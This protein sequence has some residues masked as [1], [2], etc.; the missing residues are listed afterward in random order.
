MV[1]LE[2]RDADGQH[3][4]GSAFHIDDG[5][6]VT[7]RHVVDN[8]EIVRAA[9]HVGATQLSLESISVLLPSDPDVDLTILK[10]DSPSELTTRH[11]GGVVTCGLSIT[12]MW[13]STSTTG[14]TTASC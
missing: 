13:G 11:A 8:A 1:Y 5:Y 10:T 3:S 7:A 12:S 14:S 4:V 6:L 9:P 2:T